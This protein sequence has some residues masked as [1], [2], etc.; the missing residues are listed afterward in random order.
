MA[1]QHVGADP[2]FEAVVDRAQVQVVDLDGA[3]VAF[4][5]GQ[6]LVGGDDGGGVELVGGD[7]G[8]QHVDAVEGGFGVDLGRG[9]G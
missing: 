4:D 7:A 9:R 8:A 3:E 5:V 1:D 6:V 2:V